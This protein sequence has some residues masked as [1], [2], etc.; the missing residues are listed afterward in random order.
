[1]SNKNTNNNNNHPN[2]N[3][4]TNL[5]NNTINN[6][7]NN[8]SKNETPVTVSEPVIIQQIRTPSSPPLNENVNLKDT[9]RRKTKLT[10]KRQD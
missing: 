3:S 2:N 1:M 6:K 8:N 10:S 7:N 4:L 5:E 9:S